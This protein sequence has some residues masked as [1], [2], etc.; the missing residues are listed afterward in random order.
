MTPGPA[1]T[2]RVGRVPPAPEL[3]FWDREV[4]TEQS[5]HAFPASD[6]PSWTG[7]SI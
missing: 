1:A 5:L 6:P 7:A 4:V 2:T 3:A